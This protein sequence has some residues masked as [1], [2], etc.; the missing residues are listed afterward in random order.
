[1]HELRECVGQR[2]FDGDDFTRVWVREG[3]ANAVQG[4]A[5]E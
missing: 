5:D 4:L 1:M 3:E 2:G